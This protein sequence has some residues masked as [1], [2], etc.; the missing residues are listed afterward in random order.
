M[1]LGMKGC[2]HRCYSA[3]RP[4]SG[5]K[6][7]KLGLRVR[8]G[9]ASRASYLQEFPCVSKKHHPHG[10]DTGSQEEHPSPPRGFY[11][12]AIDVP[13]GGVSLLRINAAGR[14]GS[15]SNTI[16]VVPAFR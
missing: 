7:R 1:S 12:F 9:R 3:P 11:P 14:K 10:A 15:R 5:E 16:A 8:A 4:V 6:T 2:R 13:S